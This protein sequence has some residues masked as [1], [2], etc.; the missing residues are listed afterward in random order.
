ME[1]IFEYLTS[2]KSTLRNKGDL[3]G[4]LSKIRGIYMSSRSSDEKLMKIREVTEH[5]VRSSTKIKDPSSIAA[6]R[7]GFML[8]V[9]LRTFTMQ[10]YTNQ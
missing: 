4:L 10:H 5:V 7:T 2:N 3:M 6:T 9:V 8:Y 1:H